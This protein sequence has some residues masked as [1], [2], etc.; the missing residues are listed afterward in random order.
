[1]SAVVTT[2]QS[3][4]HVGFSRQPRTGPAPV[5]ASPQKVR[6]LVEPQIRQLRLVADAEED[7]DTST[8]QREFPTIIVERTERCQKSEDLVVDDFA[9]RG[10]FDFRRFDEVVE[11]T[12]PLQTI[13]V[14]GTD[15]AGVAVEVLARYQRLIMRKNRAS[16]SPLFDA[17]L[18]AHASLYDVSQSLVRADLEHALDTW[19]WLLRIEPNIGLA[20][21]VAALFHDIDRLEC[22]PQERI[23]HRAHRVDDAQAKRGGERVFAILRSLGVDESDAA[24]VRALVNGR[25][26]EDADAAL[27]EDADALSF[28]SLMS[29]RYADYFGL[30]QTRRK[31]TFTLGRLGP[32]AREKVALLRLRPD[33]DRLVQPG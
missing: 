9:W 1:M 33:V 8:I 21:Q 30:A 22:E 20:P 28:L 2:N 5:L 17:V 23:E 18:D 27:L 32:V 15:A 26:H 29:P 16:S 19:Q 31:V 3:G 4:T 13:A 25:A 11:Q 10:A 12:R 14:R 6:A 24:R 7:L